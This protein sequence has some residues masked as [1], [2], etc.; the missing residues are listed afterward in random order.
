VN[1]LAPLWVSFLLFE[2]PE[3][4]VCHRCR[5]VVEQGQPYAQDMPH[6]MNGATPEVWL[7]CVYCAM[8]PL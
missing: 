1:I 5:R 8:P 6:A 7:L 4:L 3:G 2:D